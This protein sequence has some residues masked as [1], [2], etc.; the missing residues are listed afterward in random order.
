MEVIETVRKK[1]ALKNCAISSIFPNCHSYLT[2]AADRCKR[3][4]LGD[5]EENRI[6]EA[7]QKSRAEFKETEAKFVISTL[8]CI[9]SK[10]HLIELPNGW[11]VHRPNCTIMIHYHNKTSTVEPS[12]IVDEKLYCKAF[13]KEN[14]RIT[15]SCNSFNDIRLL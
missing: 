11:L 12:P 7:Y 6:Q 10:L 13:Y 1:V 15:L 14:N 2:D 3:L 9:I 8:N 5:K 4:C